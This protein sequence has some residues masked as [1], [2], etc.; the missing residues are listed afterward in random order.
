MDIGQLFINSVIIHP[1]PKRPVKGGGEPLKL[2]GIESELTPGMANFFRES[3]IKSLT[4]SSYRVAFDGATSSPVPN[5]VHGA[6]SHPENEFVAMSRQ[7]AEHLYESQN[8]SMSSGLLTVMQ[9]SVAAAP[10]IAILKLEKES[11]I[12]VQEQQRHGLSTFA[13]E[14]IPDLMLS[15]KTKVFKVGLFVQ[16]R[17]GVES[18]E[19]SI[20]DNQRGRFPTVEVADFFLKQFLGC[21]LYEAPA[22]TT[23][24]FLQTSEA[25]INEEVQDPESKARYEIGLLATLSSEEAEINPDSFAR[26]YLSLGD[27]QRY[28]AFIE[29]A[30]IPPNRPF[31]KDLSLVANS[32]KRV[33]LDFAGGTFL[34]APTEQF[35]DVVHV[36]Q[37]NDG[38]TRATIEDRLTNI[39]GKR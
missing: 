6:L 20:S 24:H 14:H 3:I 26:S 28:V 19:G 38:R 17:D 16:T 31:R 33:R 5:L 21:R 8:G 22:V 39:N 2:S 15:E 34:L 35:D 7:I 11:G 4:A 30:G 10:A 12:R 9:A 29:N 25:F 23:K 37:L 1:V 32:L 27:R 36:E 18:I 13:I